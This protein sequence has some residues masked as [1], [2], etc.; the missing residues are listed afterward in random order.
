[1]SVRTPAR[2]AVFASGGGTN[3]QAL[4]DHF[5]ARDSAIARVELVVG[6]RDGIGALDR[7]RRSNVVASTI[8]SSQL[9][10]AETASAMLSALE[11][12]QIDL[13]VLA[14]YV[15]LIPAT[16]VERYRGRLI[17][18]HPALLPSFGG[19]GMYGLRVHQAV[20]ASGARVSGATVHLV[21]EHYDEGG[22][23]A[24]WPVPVFPDDTPDYLAA[25]VLLVEHRLLPAAIESLI[26][27]E[28]AIRPP[29]R[30]GSFGLSSRDV[31]DFADIIRF[32]RAPGTEAR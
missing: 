15:R 30:A 11:V 26:Q 2:L 3:L 23:I 12:H 18:I 29:Q 13:L 4:L 17:N 21:D 28:T 31:P 24:Q 19:P 9:G 25:R 10:P 5:N 7:A 27:G 14:G 6:S 32:L 20:I 22:I 16:V 1:M 8:D